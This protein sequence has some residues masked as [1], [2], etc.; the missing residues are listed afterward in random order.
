VLLADDHPGMHSALT[1]LLM[2]SVP[3]RIACP[4][5]LHPAWLEQ[6]GLSGSIRRVY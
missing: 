1:R 3:S 4:T 2:P 5:I 6:L